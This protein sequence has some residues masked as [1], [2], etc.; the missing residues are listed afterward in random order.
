MWWRKGLPDIRKGA[1]N[2]PIISILTLGAFLDLGYIVKD[3][4]HFFNVFY[5]IALSLSLIGNSKN[6]GVLHQETCH[7]T[8]TL[9]GLKR[10][11]QLLISI[12]CFIQQASSVS[13]TREWSR[14]FAQTCCHFSRDEVSSLINIPEKKKRWWSSVFYFLTWYR[15]QNVK[16]TCNCWAEAFVGLRRSSTNIRFVT[17]A[18]WIKR[19]FLHANH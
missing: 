3:Y 14:V 16:I 11:S 19:E 5:I 8:P 10:F 9:N 13:L 17:T 2:S 12:V 7:R 15:T 6:F 1:R 4:E 18:S